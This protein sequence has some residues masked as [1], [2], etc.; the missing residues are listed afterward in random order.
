MREQ[1]S[2]DDGRSKKLILK[3]K[4]LSIEEIKEKN[5]YNISHH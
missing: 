1:E 4:R 5:N 3:K 2:V